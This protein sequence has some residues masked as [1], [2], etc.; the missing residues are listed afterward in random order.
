MPLYDWNQIEEEKMNPLVSRKAIH[1]ENLTIARIH[2]QQHAVVAVH[3]HMNEQ[4]T[5]IELGALK[6]F[7]DGGEKIVRAGETL[8]IPSHVAHGVEALEDTIAV[9]VFSPRREDWL[10]GDDAY[11]RK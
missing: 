6:F 1:T 4:V 8:T 11:L 7:I 9:D 5:T 10:R 3:S 2:L